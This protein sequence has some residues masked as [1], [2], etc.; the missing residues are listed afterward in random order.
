MA[1]FSLPFCLSDNASDYFLLF[2]GSHSSVLSW[3]FPSSVASCFLLSCATS[4]PPS[5]LPVHHPLPF[6]SPLLHSTPLY[7]ISCSLSVYLMNTL[8]LV[9]CMSI[10]LLSPA[11]EVE[12]E[13]TPAE[14]R[15]CRPYKP[16]SGLAACVCVP[17]HSYWI[18]VGCIGVLGRGNNFS[19][20][21]ALFPCMI[22][23]FTKNHMLDVFIF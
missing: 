4:L 13:P 15:R 12:Q 23:S 5:F 22:L 10:S 21:W 8:G 14:V 16:R 20:I 3:V 19:T 7:F 17:E 2:P 1:L 9:E 6:S 11:R 18:A